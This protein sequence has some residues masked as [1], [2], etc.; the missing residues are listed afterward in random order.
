MQ[1]VFEKL[2]KA[3]FARQGQTVPHSHQVATRLIAILK[4]LPGNQAA[5]YG[6]ERAFAAV[7]ELENAQPSVVA[8]AVRNGDVAAQYP[9]LEYPWENPATNA[10]EWPA[11]HLPIARRIQDPADRVGADLLRT[12]RSLVQHFNVLFL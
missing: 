8:S 9:Q 6:G 4:R 3:A 7:I 10:V 11:M 12:A 2:A 1:M 5:A